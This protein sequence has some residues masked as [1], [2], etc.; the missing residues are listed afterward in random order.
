ML[1]NED[2]LDQI[3]VVAAELG[4]N[5]AVI[6]KDLYLTHAISIINQ[7]EHK[8]FDLI[9]QGGTSLA[10]AYRIIQ[11]MSEDADF[12]IRF[13]DSE[14]LLSHE[15]KRKALRD[16]R[17]QLVSELQSQGYLID[18]PDIQVRN[19]GQFMSL[20]V[21]YPSVFAT[22]VGIKPYL[23]LE[24]FQ[25]TVR[26]PVEEKI[27]TSLIKQVL[28]DR[29][30]HQ[31]FNIKCISVIE[32]AT[33]KWVALTRRVA[34][35]SQHPHYRDSTLVRHLYDLFEIDKNGY[36]TED[37]QRLVV[38]IIESDRQQFKSHNEAYFQN[39][40]Q[41]IQRAIRE[42]NDSPEWKT[43]WEQFVSVMVYSEMTPGYLEVV[44]NINTKTERALKILHILSFDK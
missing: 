11:R 22:V 38:D 31:Q 16:F 3:N 21:Q 4:L 5:P 1:V 36:F 23:S 12:R 14:E 29:V 34:T 9:F 10:K 15:A 8:N 42:L 2:I 25:G 18:E 43:H 6:E 28:G 33:E 27:V 26:T 44:S 13:K 7:V 24:F 19:E 20:R 37:F 17:H 40:V 35:A 39:P 30:D 32:T 41:E